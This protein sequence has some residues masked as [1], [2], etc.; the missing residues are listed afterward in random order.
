MKVSVILPTKNEEKAIG[1]ILKRCREALKNHD[2]EL[3][4]VDNSTDKTP[5]IAE[6]LG[7]RVIRNM[8]GYGRAYIEGLRTAEGEVVVMLDADGSYDPMEIPKL[9]EPIVSNKADMVIGSR[10]LGEIKHGAMNPI[11]KLGN[12]LLTK[13]TNFFFKSSF[14]DV[15]SGM[16][17]FRRDALEKVNLV[18]PGMEFASEMIIEFA[19]KGLKIAEVPITY[20][21][22]KGKSKLNS[23]RDGWRHLRFMLLYSSTALFVIPSLV[24]LAA[25][26][27]LTAYV[28]L[29]D[30]I[31]VHSLVLGSLLTVL[32]LQTLFFGVASKIYSVEVGLTSE[33]KITNFFSRYSVLEE[34]ILA[35]LIFIAIGFGI[36]YWVFKIWYESGFGQLNQLS[37]A[38]LSFLLMTVGA[39][40]ILNSFF[41]SSLRLKTSYE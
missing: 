36:G 31:R 34:G 22:R 19:R 26:V 21:P 33:D 3:I 17:A 24:L 7:A 41:I 20:Y 38:I 6:E 1:A 27:G 40:I 13:L 2:Y 11:H 10:F 25:G 23:F 28:L 15:H 14:T 39:Q 29:L 18:C 16:R 4:V 35:G 32:G 8:E 37:M 12:R 5:D 30:P 9:I